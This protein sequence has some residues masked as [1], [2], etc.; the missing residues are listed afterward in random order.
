[1]I[2]EFDIVTVLTV[3][4]FGLPTLIHALKLRLFNTFN[5]D[6]LTKACNKAI[7]TQVVVAIVLAILAY[8]LD[9]TLYSIGQGNTLTNVIVST[10]M[11]YIISAGFFYIPGLLLLNLTNWISRK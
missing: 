3:L 10:A 5:F 1:M 6:T 11:T 7:T 9:K 4:L 2:K 8:A